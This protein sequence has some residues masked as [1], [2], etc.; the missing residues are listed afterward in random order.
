MAETIFL[1]IGGPLDG[2]RLP[3]RRDDYVA[4]NCASRSSAR[5]KREGVSQVFIH[6]SILGKDNEQTRTRFQRRPA[7]SP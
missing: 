5:D 1:H 2:Q 4:Y 6:R 7:P 3:S